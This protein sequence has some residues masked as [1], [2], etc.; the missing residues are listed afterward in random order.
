MKRSK[1][2][3]VRLTEAEAEALR[4]AADR[5]GVSL[6]DHLRSQIFPAIKPPYPIGT[7]SFTTTGAAFVTWNAAA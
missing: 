5:L 2:V 4:L 1:V 6:S 3:T 7:A